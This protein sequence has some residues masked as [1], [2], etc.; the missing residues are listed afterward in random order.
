M[1]SFF[2]RTRDGPGRTL[3]CHGDMGEAS[4]TTV[5]R[6]PTREP[7][8]FYL[9]EVRTIPLLSP[10]EELALAR[11]YRRTRDPRIAQRLVRANLRFVIRIAREY[12]AEGGRMSDLVQEG[13]LGLVQAVERFDPERQVRLVSYAVTWIRS[14]IL[15]HILHSW[16]LVKI[17]TTAGQR[18]LFFSLNRTQGAMARHQDPGDGDA[19]ARM[20]PLLARCLG[21]EPSAVEE[22]RLRLDGRDLSLD[23][24]VSPGGGST[25]DRVAS[26]TERP[27]DLLALAEE[28][29]VAARRVRAALGCLDERERL[30]IELRVMTEDPLTLRAVGERLGC[31]R[32]RARQLEVRARGKLRSCLEGCGVEGC[33]ASRVEARAR[34]RRATR[35]AAG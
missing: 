29:S 2:T 13:N 3:G 4:G 35:P 22:M 31:G 9:S 5:A 14:R 18:R 11:S 24:P 15:N 17:G 23:A 1:F 8:A 19:A 27:D 32:E 28:S 20:V 7:F 16:S 33:P 34:P 30:V 10:E 6:Q 25:L 12:R 26:A 21:V